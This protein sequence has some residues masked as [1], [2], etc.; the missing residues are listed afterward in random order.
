MTPLNPTKPL[1]TR[2]TERVIGAVGV[3]LGPEYCR[4]KTVP[5]LFCGVLILFQAI[6]V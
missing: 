1:A 3:I 5:I 6:L 4:G 2:L